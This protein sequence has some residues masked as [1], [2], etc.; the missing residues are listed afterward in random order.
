MAGIADVA[1][2]A[3]VSKA[4][5]SRALSGAG[6]VSQAT[7]ARVQDAATRLGYVPSTSAVSLATGRTQNI[8][9][10]MPYLNRWFFAEVLEGIQQALLERDLDLTLYDAKPGSPGRARIFDDFLARKRFDGLIAVGLEPVDREIDQLTL[11][12]RPIV[13]VVG[14]GKQTSV[15]AVDDDLAARRATEHL[16]ELGHRNIAFVGGSPRSHWAHVDQER[17]AGYRHAMRQAGLSQFV[18]HAHSEVT[19]PGGY[20]AAADLLGDARNRPTAIVGVC[21]EV[22]IGAMIAAR[23]LGILVPSALSVVG[24]D[25]HEFAEMFALTTLR[26]VPREQGMAAVEV[27]LAEIDDPNRQRTHLRMPARLIMRTSTA[28]LSAPAGG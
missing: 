10:V 27:L 23:R 7:R 4:T 3:G 12:G 19:M 22:A 16:I 8:G 26:Q 1:A 5:A 28:P 20:A 17:L 14:S 25:D 2:L 15:V 9:V 13:S 21:D 24:I 6:Y 11:I 18:Q